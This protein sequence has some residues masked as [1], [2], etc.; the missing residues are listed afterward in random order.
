MLPG[1]YFKTTE[2]PSGDVLACRRFVKDISYTITHDG[3]NGIKSVS[4]KITPENRKNIGDTITI[5]QSVTFVAKSEKFS[6]SNEIKNYRAHSPLSFII[7]GSSSTYQPF[8]GSSDCDPQASL[9]F[10]ISSVY[11]CAVTIT[12]TDTACNSVSTPLTAKIPSSLGLYENG[13]IGNNS[14]WMALKW[15]EGYDKSC[16]KVLKSINLKIHYRSTGQRIDPK[17]SITS[18]EVTSGYDSV[19]DLKRLG[20]M[21]KDKFVLYFTVTFINDDPV[22]QFVRSSLFDVVIDRFPVYDTPVLLLILALV[23]FFVVSGIIVCFETSK[24]KF[25]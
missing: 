23:I 19:T 14:Q 18:A 3:A 7:G 4:V 22:D 12:P 6:Y 24:P 1:P 25:L 11:S 15:T 8:E 16:D 17:N 10:P 13:V 20:F 9:S 5:S 21:T 2:F